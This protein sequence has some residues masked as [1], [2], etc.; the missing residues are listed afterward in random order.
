NT[1]SWSPRLSSFSCV[2]PH[3]KS[4]TLSKPTKAVS[5]RTPFSFISFSE[6]GRHGSQPVNKHLATF[7]PY[8][9]TCICPVPS[10]RKQRRIGTA[11]SS[12][13]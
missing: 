1:C 8:A 6:R 12:S 7:L 4:A 10:S 13:T 3:Q 11:I 5:P 2:C 9:A